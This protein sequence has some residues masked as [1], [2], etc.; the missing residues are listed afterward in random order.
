[1]ETDKSTVAETYP[2]L[3]DE[4]L[5]EQGEDGKWSQWEGGRGRKKNRQ[6]D[7]DRWNQTGRKRVRMMA[8]RESARG[9]SSVP[10]TDR[11]E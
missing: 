2:R 4:T 8:E 3:V 10:E 5:T 7:R 6:T 9:G 11:R 1:M